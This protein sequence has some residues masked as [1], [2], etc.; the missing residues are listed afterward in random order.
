MC[1]SCSLLLAAW[2]CC[3]FGGLVH[4]MY[5]SNL[6]LNNRHQVD[7]VDVEQFVVTIT[8]QLS[9]SPT[10][11]QSAKVAGDTGGGKVYVDDGGDGQQTLDDG[12]MVVVR[13]EKSIQIQ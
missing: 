4:S 1:C 10:S 6:D 7:E 5:D 11:A 13:R 8:I 2:T 9:R 3:C 12:L